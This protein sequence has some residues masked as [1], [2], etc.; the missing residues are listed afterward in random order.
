MTT[1]YFHIGLHKTGTSAIQHGLAKNRT[2]LSKIG[3]YYGD[4]E[5]FEAHH[6]IAALIP[7]TE[8]GVP[9]ENVIS[10]LIERFNL[11]KNKAG[12][13][14]VIIS[15]E[16]FVERGIDFPLLAL[17]AVFKKVVVI[18][19]VRRQDIM[20]ESVYN[21]IVKQ[22]GEYEGILDKQYYMLDY[23]KFVERISKYINV[24]KNMI[25]GVYDINEIQCGHI[26][27]DFINVIG[28]N[29]MRSFK[30]NNKIV[31]KSLNILSLEVM[32]FVNNKYKK[33]AKISPR[34]LNDITE[35]LYP[36]ISVP[37]VGNYLTYEER[38]SVFNKYHDS[39][40]KLSTLLK[41]DK[42]IFKHPDKNTINRKLIKITKSELDCVIN[43]YILK[44][45]SEC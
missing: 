23:Y 44:K 9:N 39:N 33:Y 20:L 17:S 16:M 1:C 36:K 25:L 22:D 21:Q 2:A 5:C 42:F 30:V 31:N 10:I 38:L 24:S 37:M 26:F 11:I 15:S 43:S 40:K 32:R 14:D 12:G 19:Y 41:G 3:Y 45:I 28:I 18:M 4:T 6:N 34:D 7:N 29:D 8:K 27:V 35:Y 13:R